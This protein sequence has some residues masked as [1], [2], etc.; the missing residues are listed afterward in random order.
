MGNNPCDGMLSKF[1]KSFNKF[2]NKRGQVNSKVSS[3]SS[4]LDNFQSGDITDTSTVKDKINEAKTQINN[5][6]N[7][8][9][10]TSSTLTGSCLDGV[11]NQM[12]NVVN[13]LGDTIN[14]S[15]S[16]DTPETGILGDLGVLDELLGKLAIPDIIKGLDELLGCL[17]DSDCIPTSE[18]DSYFNEINT[19]TDTNGLLPDGT[20]DQDEFLNKKG[21]SPDYKEA[22]NSFK[23]DMGALK[24][25]AG[26]VVNSTKENVEK[27]KSPKVEVDQ[28]L[29]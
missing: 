5:D 4:S 2:R 11:F 10:D 28:E 12:K 15:L 9:Q 6:M 27:I 8:V 20:F 23:D 13:N 17:S 1:D 22:L 16:T 18:I 14:N 21:V 7:N 24:D 29:F 26:S 25:E 3:I 19:F